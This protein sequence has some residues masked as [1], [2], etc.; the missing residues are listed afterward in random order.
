MVKSMIPYP[1]GKSL[2][3]SHYLKL[4]PP[5]HL[6]CEVFC[7]AAHIT[8]RK[9]PATSKLEIINDC[10]DHL[11]NFFQVIKTMPEEFLRCADM[12]LRARRTFEDYMAV[13]DRPVNPR[14]NAQA[15]WRFYYLIRN[16]FTGSLS[17]PRWKYVRARGPLSRNVHLANVLKKWPE[18]MDVSNRLQ[19]VDIECL[20]FRD[21]ISRYDGD[22]AMF[23]LDPPYMTPRSG[24]GDYRYN[25]KE[26][27]HLDLAK[28]LKGIRGKFMLTY[29][30][31]EPVRELYDWATIMPVKFNYSVPHG[32]S[33]GDSKMGLELVITNYDPQKNLG[34]LFSSLQNM[35]SVL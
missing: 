23:F 2:M 13:L 24:P 16:S 30:D 17:Y 18:I 14:P 15:A 12:E 33:S 1:G 7:G 4:V 3:S 34:P 31:S 19:N 21:C 20:D 29:E 6:W 22:G 5:H 27:D 11:V 28:I 10:F 32:G 25:F 26:D 9:D 8:L 35:D